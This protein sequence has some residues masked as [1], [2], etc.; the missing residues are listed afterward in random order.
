M[1][2]DDFQRLVELRQ[3]LRVGP[4]SSYPPSIGPSVESNYDYNTQWLFDIFRS[5]RL[6]PGYRLRLLDYRWVRYSGPYMF[7]VPP[8]LWSAP[9]PQPTEG[10]QDIPG[11]L[12]HF[13]DAVEGDDTAW[14]YL[15]ASL[16]A[17][18]ADEI[19]AYYTGARFGDQQLVDKCPRVGGNRPPDPYSDLSPGPTE[20]QEEW[21][22]L[23]PIPTDWLP[24]VHLSQDRAIVT[25][26][27][28]R[29]YYGEAI[30]RYTDTYERGCYRPQCEEVIVATG[31]NLVV[32]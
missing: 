28:Y 10:P 19:G 15:C 4:P 9:V 31:S 22:W 26:H 27:T 11:A 21:E 29:Y 32:C 30:S 20:P 25:F 6:K 5:L 13:M 7:A 24:Q 2:Q 3:K 18:D 17:R 23:E 1:N 16:L 8:E 14:S 12:E